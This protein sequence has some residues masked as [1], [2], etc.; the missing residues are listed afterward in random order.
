[1]TNRYMVLDIL[2]QGTKQHY[3]IMSRERTELLP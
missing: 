1:M 2:I 3:L